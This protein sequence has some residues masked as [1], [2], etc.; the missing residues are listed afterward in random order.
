MSLY[1]PAGLVKTMLKCDDETAQTVV[2]NLG[3]VMNHAPTR[4][5]LSLAWHLSTTTRNPKQTRDDVLINEGKR[6]AGLFLVA[7]AKRGLDL[8]TYSAP[9]GAKPEGVAE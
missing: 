8:S 9:T 1:G 7:C 5:F 3:G 4:A 2:S 6:Q